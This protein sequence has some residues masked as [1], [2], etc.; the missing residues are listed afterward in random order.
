[1]SSVFNEKKKLIATLKR[2][3]QAFNNSKLYII[4]LIIYSLEN[5]ST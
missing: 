3:M 4:S 5:T 2:V 1:M